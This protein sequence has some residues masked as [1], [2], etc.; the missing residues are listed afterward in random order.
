L[1]PGSD[2]EFQKHSLIILTWKPIMDTISSC[3]MQSRKTR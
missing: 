2:I 3:K 1:L